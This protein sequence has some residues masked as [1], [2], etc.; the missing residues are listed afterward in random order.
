MNRRE[1][2]EFLKLGGMATAGLVSAPVA[3]LASADRSRDEWRNKL[4]PMAY[5]RLGK[6]GYMISEF[7]CGGNTISPANNQH[8][9]L[10]LDMGLN[11][12]DTAPAYG[13][14]ES[15]LGY[16]PVIDS[17]SKRQRVFLATKVSPWDNHRSDLF[18]KIFESL[19]DAEKQAIRRQAEEDLALRHVKDP[20]YFCNY[21]DAQWGEVERAAIAN[22][23]DKRYG[24]R[25]D[26]KKEYLGLILQ[27]VDE[28]LRR[29]RTDYLDVL[30]CPHGAN[31]PQEMKVE[32]IFEAFERLKKAGKVRHLGFSSHSD[33][34]GTLEAA[35]ESGMYSMGMVAYN[36]INHRYVDRA[37]AAAKKKD[38]GIIAMK[39][40]R[41][42]WAGRNRPVPPERVEKI[43]RAVPGDMK[44]PMKAYL[45]ALQNPNIAGINSELINA[46]MVKDNLPLA[47]KR[48]GHYAR[49]EPRERR[50]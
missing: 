12:L 28:S 37:L 6:T 29:L 20:D 36:I 4:S 3:E 33:P 11:Y 38:V 46:E 5:R 14:G 48:I 44:I 24:S 40:A 13:K 23:M 41:P 2:L 32:E 31:T 10:A 15:E 25:I 49:R 16:S 42:V 35:V 21:F 17:S 30:L 34:G 22:A 50:G 8:V 45:W 43:Q 18:Q 7:V 27:S 39:V 1:F 26:K 47:G 19:P 9:P